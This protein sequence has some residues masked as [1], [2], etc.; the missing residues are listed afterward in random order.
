M[1]A[2]GY[3]QQPPTP[4]EPSRE[5]ESE[6]LPKKSFLPPHTLAIPY[7]N[8]DDLFS[9]GEISPEPR[10]NPQ[11]SGLGDTLL[12]DRSSESVHVLK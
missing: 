10:Y 3:Q 6:L 1:A 9:S 11:G 2:Q 5:I 8:K 4:G 7:G 12:S